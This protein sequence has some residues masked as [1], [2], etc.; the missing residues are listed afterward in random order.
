MTPALSREL[1]AEVRRLREENEAL[2]ARLRR[3]GWPVSETHEAL[4]A[5]VQPGRC[6]F[7][8]EP[9]PAPKRK[10]GRQREVCGSLECRRS[11][12]RLWHADKRAV[13]AVSP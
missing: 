4:R 13:K 7:C 6:L 11:R 10:G 2:K 1:A 8:E 12:D 3:L 5:E 9:L